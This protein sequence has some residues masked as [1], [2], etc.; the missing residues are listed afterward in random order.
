M[1][2]IILLASDWMCMRFS[3]AIMCLVVIVSKVVKRVRRYDNRKNVFVYANDLLGDTMVK[4]PFFFALREQFP[5]E[6]YN[7]MVV[8]SPVMA[9]C[10]RKL[11][12]FDEV[13]EESPLHWRHSVFWLFGHSGMAKSLRWAFCHKAEVMIVCHRSR[14]LGCDF[15]LSLCNPSVSVAYSADI[16]TPMLPMTARYQAKVCDKRYTYLLE[17]KDG[18][19][20]MEDMDRLL[21]FAAGRQIKSQQ[22]RLDKVMAA[23]D[24]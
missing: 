3:V 8:L 2:N 19:H 12:L 23:F 9:E 6:R 14:S 11:A 15:A 13:I 21:S 7:I 24:F 20:Q 22:L 17:S 10:L 1:N 4:F 18:C 5:V 16:K